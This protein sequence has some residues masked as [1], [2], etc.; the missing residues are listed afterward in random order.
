MKSFA[1]AEIKRVFEPLSARYN[2]E[3]TDEAAVIDIHLDDHI[4]FL[5]QAL[6][7]FH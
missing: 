5:F 3:N 6:Q 7:D 2:D 1:R 4:S